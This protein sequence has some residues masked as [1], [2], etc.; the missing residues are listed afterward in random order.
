M[1]KATI[2]VCFLAAHPFMVAPVVP[3]SSHWQDDF[4]PGFERLPS[5]DPSDHPTLLPNLS[6]PEHQEEQVKTA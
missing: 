1:I 6:L 5:P 4:F 2:L 3:V